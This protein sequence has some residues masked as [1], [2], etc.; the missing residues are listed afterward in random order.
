M[1]GCM[2]STAVQTNEMDVWAKK[3]DAA[4]SAVV[5]ANTLPAGRGHRAQEAAFKALELA[6]AAGHTLSRRHL[7]KA[8]EAFDKTVAH[9]QK[10]LDILCGQPDEDPEEVEDVLKRATASA[11]PN[12]PHVRR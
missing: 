10:C 11:L 12:F 7:D 5:A 4:M 1:G 8:L 2:S 6:A 3:M 9:Q